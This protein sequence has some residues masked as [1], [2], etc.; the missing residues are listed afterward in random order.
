MHTNIPKTSDVSTSVSS[1]VTPRNSSQ[2]ETCV[3]M[4]PGPKN[5]SK[6]HSCSESMIESLFQIVGTQ[7]KSLES[8]SRK[9]EEAAARN[10][11]LTKRVKEL[12]AENRDLISKAGGKEN[13]HLVGESKSEIKIEG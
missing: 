2:P 9:V 13:L 12:E 7:T 1:Q 3:P 4:C 8:L 5:S 11:S 6:R 10:I